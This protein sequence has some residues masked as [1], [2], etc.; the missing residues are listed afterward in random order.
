MKSKYWLPLVLAVVFVVGL[1]VGS[2]INSSFHIKSNGLNKLVNVIDL[3]EENY[4]DEVDLDS[5]VEMTI[6]AMISNLDPHSSY[7]NSRDYENSNSELEGKISG[8]GITF[9]ILHDTITVMEVS[10]GG[11]SERK[12]IMPGDRIVK[13]DGENV[14]GKK[15]KANDVMTRLRGE[16]GTHV[17]VSVKRASSKI[18]LHFEIIRDDVPMLSVESTYMVDPKT[19]YIKLVR[20]SRN[21][22]SEFLQA[23]NKLR[24]EGAERY[25]IDLRSNTGGYMEPAVMMINEFLDAGDVIVSLRGRKTSENHTIH[26]D[27][28][29]A[30]KDVDLVVLINESTASAS[31][32]FSGAIQDNDRGWVI[33]RR[34][35]GKG[36][37][38]HPILLPDSS[39][40]RL[41]VQRYYTP[42]GR[43]IQK[44]YKSGDN[45]QYEAELYNRFING[46]S[47]SADSIKLNLNDNYLTAGGRTVYGGGGIMPD[48][49]VPEDTTKI[50]SYYMN[51]FN[52]N[53][54]QRFAYEYTDLNRSD[55]EKAKDVDQLLKKLPSDEILISSFAHYAAMNG[56][57]A[58]WY[59]INIS[60]PLIVNEIKA[61]IARNILGVSAFYE[62]YNRNDNTFNEALKYVEKPVLQDK[63]ATQK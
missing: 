54:I 47:L 8:I 52:Q 11:P 44:E 4:V 21:T 39:E 25:I 22:Y 61:D 9:N 60:S 35:F 17:M 13:I 5:L 32:I 26:A 34:S 46:E 29:G 14:A 57:P 40:L 10:P 15:I 16:K 45:D 49:F 43:S 63:T 59:Y 28:T 56:I 30:F 62:L 55:L 24:L 2:Q 7:I 33:G 36:L 19:G 1:L 51:V 38:Q 18:P 37:V 3:I 50:T 27:G 20:F 48:V 31:E 53:M 12:G 6:P 23:L 58:R 42:S 41:T